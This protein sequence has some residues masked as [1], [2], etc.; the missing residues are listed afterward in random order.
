MPA[1]A[2]NQASENAAA[3]TLSLLDR[4]IAEGRMAHDDSQ[5]DYARDMLA[6]FATQVLDEGMAIDKDTVAMINDRISKIDELISAQ[7]NEVLHHPDLQKL[8]ASWRGLHMLVQNTE[9]STRLKLRLLN[10]TQKELQNDLEKAVEFDQS[11]L[12]KKIYEE[13]YGTFGGHPFSLLVGDYTF[14]RH[15]QDIGLLEKLSN[16]A[17]AAHAPFIAAASPRL[18]DMNS[19]TELAVPRDLSKVFESQEL[20]K[21]RSFRES[22]DSRYV[23][24]VLPHFLLRL[25]YG[26]DT[27]PVEGIN[28]VED[29][30][31]TDHSKY[32]WGNAAWALSQRITEAFAK[33]GWCAAIRGAEGGGAVEGLPAHTFR[34]SSGDLS[35]KCPTEVAITDRREKELN[36]LGFIAL[37]HKKN[38][39]I[40]VFFGGQTTNKSKVYNTNE[41]NANARISAMLPYVLAASRFAHYLKVIMRDKVGSF[42]TRDNVQTYLNNWIADYV[43]INDNAPQEI[44]AQYPLREARVD[45]TEVA[46]KPGAYRATVFLRPHFQLEELTASIRLVATLPPPVAA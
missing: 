9:T 13:E 14:G 34:T 5:Q 21:W 22:E 33:Y 26:P 29:T 3:E 18:F 10:V 11:A 17:A 23:S 12:F 28:Y 30:N 2:Q 19:F 46:G 35:L 41:A 42:M 43:L 4:I 6:E 16:V 32:L 15:P 40:A 45:V 39:D 37:C 36:D 1:A 25:P 8:E 31:G 38:S 7:L 24:L 44:K 27:S 20:I